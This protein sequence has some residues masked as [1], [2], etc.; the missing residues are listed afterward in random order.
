MT[1]AAQGIGRGIA[2]VLAEAGAKIVIGDIQDA[3]ST[4]GEIRESGGE[5]VTML[6][7]TSSA[8]DARAL[9]DLALAE[10]ERLDS[11]VNNAA[12]DAPE[13]NA[14]DLTDEEWRRMIDVNLS[15]LFYC[16]KAALKPMLQVGK[17]C[18][19]NIRSGAARQGQ[20]GGSPAYNASK[21]GVL[22]LTVAFSAQVA[23]RGVR[24]NAVMPG[25]ILSRDFGW[26][27]EE[28]AA[29]MSLVPLGF[30]MHRDIGGA[31]RYLVSPAARWVTG[32]ALQVHGG[33]IH[34]GL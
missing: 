8:D 26:S 21:A 12:I 9:V 3:S 18:I 1:G 16:S 15:G 17:G 28:T 6:M 31:V 33:N 5:A 11:L 30:G 23:D 10:Y 32:T 13:G 2:T 14:W 24:V 34:R 29:R 7:D 20:K 4:A 27:A 25:S 19:V 22:G